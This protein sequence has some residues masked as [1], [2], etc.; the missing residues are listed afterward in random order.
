MSDRR[1][2]QTASSP[3]RLTLV[4]PAVLVMSATACEGERNAERTSGVAGARIQGV[5]TTGFVAG[6]PRP[7]APAA[8]PFA[9]DPRAMAQGRELYRWYNCAGCHG[10]LGGGGIGPPL[11]DEE[12]IYGSDPANIFQS[13]VQGRPNG[14]PSFD[15][16]VDEQ[17][18]KIVLH[19]RELGGLPE[20]GGSG[21]EDGRERAGGGAEGGGSR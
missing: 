5:R 1:R 18:W 10:V 3:A 19:V 8:N 15:L 6:E 16:L 4:L 7:R 21:G 9:G 20:S 11:I 17:V 2:H 14:M 12:W 13:I